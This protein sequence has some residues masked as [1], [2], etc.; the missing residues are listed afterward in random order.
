MSKKDETNI[1]LT[2]NQEIYKTQFKKIEILNEND[3]LRDLSNLMENHEFKNFF[4]K[5]LGDWCDVRCSII[6][7]KY[8]LS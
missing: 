6:Y 1:V 4:D 5:Y 2:K 8:I 3:F 7:I